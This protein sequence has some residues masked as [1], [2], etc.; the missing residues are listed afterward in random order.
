MPTKEQQ[1]VYNATKKA[2]RKKDRFEAMPE[3][4]ALRAELGALQR[5]I[6]GE[7]VYMGSA[8]YESTLRERVE[9]WKSKY[10][11]EMFD[12]NSAQDM[13]ESNLRFL[14]SEM[15]GNIDRVTEAFRDGVE[16]GRKEEAAPKAARATAA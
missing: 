12:K 13:R 7:Q 5:G 6:A 14:K 10:E 8:D 11:E 1:A 9:L 16:C 4:Q 2:K 3:A 15:K